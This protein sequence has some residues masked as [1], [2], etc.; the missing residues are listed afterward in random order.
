[1]TDMKRALIGV[2]LAMVAVAAG[3]QS[4]PLADVTGGQIRGEPLAGG[5]AV[6][7]GIPYAAPPV[8]DLRWREPMPVTAWTGVRDTT[9]FGAICPQNP[10]AS[11]PDAAQI[12]REDCLFLNIW[13]SE[14]PVKSRRPVLFWIPGGG[15]IFGGASEPRH[16]GER[17]ARRGVVVV[18]I[19][20]RVG[21]FGF[22]SHPDLTRE[23]PHA[24]SGNQGLLDQLAALEWVRVNAQKFGGDPDEITL[25]GSSAGAIDV[26]AVMASPL[27]AGRFKR[28]ILQSE[29]A[30]NGPIGDLMPRA[31]AEQ[32]GVKHTATWGVPATAS[33]RELR[34]VPVATI[35]A[36]QP[37]RPVAHLYL[38]VDGYVMPRHI[39]EVFAS[40]AQHKVPVLMGTS[41]RD[42][43]PGAAPPADLDALIEKTYGPLSARARALYVND[44]PLYGT[45]AVQW[46]TDTSFRCPTVMQLAQHVA[47]GNTAFAYEFARLATPE[48]QPGGN[49][50]GFDGGYVFGTFA[51]RAQGTKLVPTT[52]TAA[53]TTLSNLMQ[54]YWTNFVKT[55]NPNGPGL[56]E[57]PDFREPARAYLQFLETGPAAREGVRRSQCDL[58]IENVNRLRRPR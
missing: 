9:A 56:P 4:P 20:Y 30:R 15:N 2:G 28:A 43:T 47:A 48:I 29:P 18:T 11:I 1:M 55:G 7:K 45:A 52:F 26:A 39:D 8:G 53:D 34:T 31:V 13:T 16:D 36:A 40:G 10:S 21:S 49:I 3:T 12:S 35:L 38:S 27:S 5:G 42:F 51:T 14:W 33:L 58:Y 22:F 57:W 54:Q 17:L 46:A 24:A 37:Q 41:A 32:R 6:F 19:N 23:S 44:D 25:A 50:H